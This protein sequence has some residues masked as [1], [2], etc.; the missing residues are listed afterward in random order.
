MTLVD[1]KR[2]WF[3]SKVGLTANETSRDIA[4]CAHTIL[5]KDVFVIP[6]TQADERFASNPL[7][8]GDP[9]IRF[10]AGAPLITPD[11][12]ALGTLSVIDQIPR[13]LSAEQKT[14]LQ[15]LGR[16]V[17]SQLESR[18]N[19][20]ELRE[21]VVQL[22]KTEE[23]WRESEEK[24]HQLADNITDAFWITSLDFKIRHYVSAGYETIW[25]RSK[26][27]LYADPGQWMEAILPEER[28]HVFAV[29]A[30]LKADEPRVSVEYRIVRPDGAIRW[31]LDRGFQIRD[32]AGTLIRLAGI[33]TDI[34]ERRGVEDALDRQQTELRVLFDIVPAMICFKD[35]ENRI[36][37]V[38]K[39]LAESFGTTV[40]E[41]EGKYTSEVYPEGAVGFYADDLEVIKSGK[42]KV[43]VTNRIQ[44]KDGDERWLQTDRVPLLGTDDK[45]KGIVVMVQ[46]ITERKRGGDGSILQRATLSLAGGSHDVDGLGHPRLGPI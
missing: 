1:D 34:T 3:K 42:P 29:F 20:A 13:E 38:N 33:V 31:V 10:Y 5:Q 25:G 41:L 44:T 16:Q 19:V 23:S 26:K 24:F 8:M 7:V 6:D 43:G 45:A 27:S 22:K 21:T 11:G 17:V 18:R 39:R 32:A 4:F 30:G 15:A 35:T 14:A 12:H 40:R 37:R 9:R 46:D 36:L 28:E 2:Q